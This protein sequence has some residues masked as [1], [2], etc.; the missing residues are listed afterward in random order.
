MRVHAAAVV[1][2]FAANLQP[3]HGM[4]SDKRVS[5]DAPCKPSNEEMFGYTTSAAA[6]EAHAVR[7]SKGMMLCNQ[8]P[9]IIIAKQKLL[10]VTQQDG[11]PK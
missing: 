6:C 10:P 4:Q 11:G 9:G 2:G 3:T 8:A 5:G 1:V 7:V